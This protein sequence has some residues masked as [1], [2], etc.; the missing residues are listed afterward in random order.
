MRTNHW[1]SCLKAP[2]SGSTPP[3]H[4]PRRLAGWAALVL[5]AGLACSGADSA[6][7][8]MPPG[9][10][11][12]P[13]GVRTADV[14]QGDMVLP[15][16]V[17]RVSFSGTP[18]ANDAP[19]SAVCVKFS[20][21]GKFLA[22]AT[23][24]GDVRLMDI[25]GN[26]EVWKAARPAGTTQALAFSPEGDRVF[27]AGMAPALTV[28]CLD[29][30]SGQQRWTRAVET[31]EAATPAAGATARVLALAG[32]DA[33]AWTEGGAET[34]GA[35]CVVRL[36]ADGAVKW[37]CQG[38]AVG[39][40]PISA[41]ALSLSSDALFV[42]TGAARTG[43]GETVQLRANAL[44]RLNLDSGAVGESLAIDASLLAPVAEQPAVVARVVIAEDGKAGALL[45]PGGKVLRLPLEDGG[46]WNISPPVASGVGAMV[47]LPDGSLC[48]A[49]ADALWAMGADGNEIW[50]IRDGRRFRGLWA[51]RDGRW[52]ITAVTQKVDG[53][54]G[55]GMLLIAPGWEGEGTA[56]IAYLYRVEGDV[57][58]AS[59]MAG[60]GS[61][62]AVIEIP[63]TDPGSGRT[64]GT[65]Q[66]HVVR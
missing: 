11:M 53:P 47:R 22:A 27:L 44:C 30:G 25:Y 36:A 38:K 40:A 42:L 29:A 14:K 21:D 57:F 24:A 37:Q 62:F 19:A 43:K 64:S 65:F 12:F 56:R 63:R 8:P 54:R 2:S 17:C 41:A 5:A 58:P 45:T 59:D 35:G 23:A 4:N 1:Q 50:S 10:P 66:V 48:L 20:P 46:K 49:S 28:A 34:A 61:A 6:S 16:Q 39:E 15:C 31:P 13:P 60:D 32:G 52:L 18:P 3:G 51:S 26:R 55:T 9:I 33:L 7:W